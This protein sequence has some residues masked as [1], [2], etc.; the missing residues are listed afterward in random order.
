VLKRLYL[1]FVRDVIR[2][3]LVRVLSTTPGVCSV[4]ASMRPDFSTNKC[5]WCSEMAVVQHNTVD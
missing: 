5:S 1:Y 2:K 4:F 3:L